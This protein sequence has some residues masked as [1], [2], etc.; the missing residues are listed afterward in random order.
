MEMRPTMS[1]APMLDVTNRFF[2][3]FFRQLSRHSVL[4]T[5]MV[6]EST[7]EHNPNVQDIHLKFDPIENPVVC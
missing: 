2:R 1:I 5:E 4:Y 6:V 3:Y 7:I